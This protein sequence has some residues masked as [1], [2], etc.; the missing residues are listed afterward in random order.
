MSTGIDKI[1]TYLK[2]YL[3]TNDPAVIN[4]IQNFLTFAA[5]R[6]KVDVRNALIEL[7]EQFDQTAGFIPFPP[8]G[9][10]VVSVDIAGRNLDYV[11][12]DIFRD[13][14]DDQ[15]CYTLTGNIIFLSE[16][17]K[18]AEGLATLVYY[19]AA[20]DNQTSTYLPHLLLHAAAAEAYWFQGDTETGNNELAMYQRDAAK[21]TGWDYGN[22][23]IRL[24]GNSQWQ[25]F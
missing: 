16:P 23:T 11:P 3:V 2:S 15:Y 1:T 12:E 22:S 6:I 24:G 4:N 25:Q 7:Y 13:I 17:A 8:D 21:V 14:K 10:A 19:G 18:A 9:A 5:S 20:P